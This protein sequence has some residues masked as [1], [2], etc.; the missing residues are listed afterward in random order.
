MVWWQYLVIALGL[1]L[2]GYWLS[3][4]GA[5]A[6]RDAI[7]QRQLQNAVKGLLT[8]MNANLKLIKKGPDRALFPPL[9]KYMWNIHKSKI[10][11][12][13]FKM[14][15]CLCEAYVRIDYV[16]AVLDTR[17]VEGNRGLGPGAWETRYKNEGKKARKPME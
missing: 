15:A 3:R 6:E 16:N 11:E 1:V 2:V 13:P 9:A 17:V 7:E 8:E 10:V 14:Q 5:R 12:L 4:A